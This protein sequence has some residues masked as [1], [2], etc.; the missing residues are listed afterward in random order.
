MFPQ[1]RQV[2]SKDELVELGERMKARKEE[3]L[4]QLTA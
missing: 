3:L 2:F 4:G 1:A